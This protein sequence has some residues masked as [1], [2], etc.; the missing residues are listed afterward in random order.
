MLG[1]NDSPERQGSQGGKVVVVIGGAGLIGKELSRS[2][3][4]QGASLVVADYNG[5][6]VKDVVKELSGQD[7]R[8]MGLEVDITSE[9]SVQNALS[10]ILERFETIDSVINA[11]YPKNRNYGKRFEEIRYVD[12]CD[13]ISMHLGGFFLVC[14]QIAGV[15]KK[16][17][18]GNIINIASIYGSMAPRFHLYEGT[19]MTMPIEYAA[20]KSGVIHMS[21][22]IAQYLKGYDIRCNTVSYGGILDGQP[23]VFLERY[24]SYCSGKGMLVP[25][26]TCGI[27]L[28]LLSD[29]SMSINGIDIVVDN[30]F[31]L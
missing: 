18:Y 8:V 13:N 23:E 19:K 26:D 14:Q 11:A 25:K 16:Q 17:G 24:N 28:F 20:I 3:L 4:E 5:Q 22:W 30:G 21:K 27:V 1:L 29:A 7:Q 31:A 9:I 10:D 12:F 15:F 2:I 6:A